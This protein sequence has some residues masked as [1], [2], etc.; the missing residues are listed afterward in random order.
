MA[1]HYL[2]LPLDDGDE[3][4][5]FDVIATY[6]EELLD[7]GDGANI[8]LAQQC[9]RIK[10]ELGWYEDGNKTGN[11]P[12][13]D[14]F[15]VTAYTTGRDPRPN[16]EPQQRHPM[17]HVSV[18]P[19]DCIDIA[20]EEGETMS[21]III[22]DEHLMTAYPMPIEGATDGEEPRAIPINLDAEDES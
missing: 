21:Q 20:W 19:G 5:I 12:G 1:K 17:H 22:N 18:L 15:H 14:I 4:L 9:E 16:E 11:A 8:E 2:V 13:K 7:V 3:G 6:V 10:A